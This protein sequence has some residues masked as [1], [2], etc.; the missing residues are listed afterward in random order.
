MFLDYYSASNVQDFPIGLNQL[1][2]R[3]LLK[4][5]RPM[6]EHL[7]LHTLK[8]SPPS[9]DKQ[10]HFKTGEKNMDYSKLSKKELITLLQL[11]ERPISVKKPI[12]LFDYLKPYGKEQQ[13]HFIVVMLDGANHI[14]TV[15]IVSIGLVDRF[16]ILNE[17]VDLDND[18]AVTNIIRDINTDLYGCIPKLIAVD[19]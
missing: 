7:S 2:Y 10:D 4:L 19:T 5:V 15:K 14:K 1:P 3:V 16:S 11:R 8:I 9:G 18:E 17:V 13:E 6:H 12:E